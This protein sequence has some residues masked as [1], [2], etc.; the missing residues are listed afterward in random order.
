M[1]MGRWRRLLGW[2][3]SVCFLV[4]LIP[5][6]DP[7]VR[8]SVGISVWEQPMMPLPGMVFTPETMLA[9]TGLVLGVLCWLAYAVLCM[10]PADR[11]GAAGGQRVVTSHARR[12]MRLLTRVIL[13][14][15]VFWGLLNAGFTLLFADSYH[16]LAPRSAAGCVVVVSFGEGMANSSGDVYLKQPDSPWIVDT[17]GNWSQVHDVT[18]D[19]IREGT[20]LLTWQGRAAHLNIWGNNDTVEFQTPP[21]GITC[22]Q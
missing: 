10:M 17:G 2:I 14:L 15:A 5:L 18:A 4:P 22:D 11:P 3:G 1:L 12:V 9:A 6:S 7:Q 13:A 19:P 20:W 8:T 16:V 21:H